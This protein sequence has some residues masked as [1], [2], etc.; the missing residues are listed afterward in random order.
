MK[1]SQVK[2]I[3]VLLLIWLTTFVLFSLMFGLLI[4][5]WGE[6]VNHTFE[7]IFIFLNGVSFL[8]GLT[9]TFASIWRKNQIRVGTKKPLSQF[10]SLGFINLD[11]GV[12]GIYRGYPVTI[13]WRSEYGESNSQAY[14]MS[15][16]HVHLKI[17]FALRRLYSSSGNEDFRIRFLPRCTEFGFVY[18]LFKPKFSG[19]KIKMDEMIDI[20]E[21]HKV[22]PVDF[23]E[24]EPDSFQDQNLTMSEVMRDLGRSIG[25]A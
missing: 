6:P 18:I 17:R 10:E 7:F 11:W 1:L 19:M 13:S 16:H 22:K 24:I 25:S 8:I 14:K 23:S 5:F 2:P 3:I 20:L 15:I 9:F 21:K 12:A 4:L